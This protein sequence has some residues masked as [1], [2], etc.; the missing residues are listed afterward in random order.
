MKK[1]AELSILCDAEV[2]LIVFSN[3]GKLHEFSSSSMTKVLER[4]RKC[5]NL[6]QDSGKDTQN[7]NIELRHLEEKVDNLQRSRR[8]LLGEDLDQLSIKDL[9]YL[10]QQLEEALEKVTSTKTQFM[11]DMI[12]ELRG[13]EQ[14][15]EGINKSLL[16]N[17]SELEGQ[18]PSDS[19]RISGG[20]W[21]STTGNYRQ[22]E[23][24]LH[25]GCPSAPTGI[26]ATHQ[27]QSGNYDAQGSMV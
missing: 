22:R 19:V 7:S 3:R 26:T 5:S 25:I 4:H 2:A 10:E 6:I 15:L 18:Y 1:A 16:R 21:H 23:P 13:K 24:T 14:L 12:E 27:R 11:L 17:F 9:Q 20:L 8:H